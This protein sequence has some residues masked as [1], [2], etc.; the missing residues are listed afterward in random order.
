MIEEAEQAIY[1]STTMT[2]R[3]KDIM[4]NLI[5]EIRKQQLMNEMNQSTLENIEALRTG[6]T[7]GTLELKK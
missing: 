5:H 6:V 4:R 1:K 3:E 2:N 7:K